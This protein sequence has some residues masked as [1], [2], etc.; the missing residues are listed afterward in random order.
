MRLEK[1]WE[2]QV[3]TN[4]CVLSTFRKGLFEIPTYYLASAYITQ[5]FLE[6]ESSALHPKI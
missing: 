6:D 2:L 3:K 5:L 4:F 1:L